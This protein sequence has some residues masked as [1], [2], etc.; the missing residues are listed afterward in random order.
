MQWLYNLIQ[1]IWTFLAD[2]YGKIFWLLKNTILFHVAV[3]TAILTVGV[4]LWRMFY[5]GISSLLGYVSSLSTA[6]GSVSSVGSFGTLLDLA[7]FIFPIEEVFAM[8]AVLIS[9]GVV[10]LSIRIVRAFIPTMT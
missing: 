8:F 3:V 6:L 4:T 5:Y 10:C 1:S 2:Y 9:Y 7:N